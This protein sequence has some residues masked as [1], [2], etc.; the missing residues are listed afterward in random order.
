M[1]PDD[2]RQFL[3]A[4]NGGQRTSGGAFKEAET[5]EKIGTI[6]IVLGLRDDPDYSIDTCSARSSRVMSSGTATLLTGRRT[7]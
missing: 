6:N 4:N 7:R 2:Y 1:L 5:N 3:P